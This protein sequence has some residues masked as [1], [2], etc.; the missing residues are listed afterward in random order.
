MTDWAIPHTSKIKYSQVFNSNDGQR[1]GLLTG[2][3]ARNI[4]IKSGLSQQILAQIWFLSDVDKDGMLTCEEFILSMHLI[5]CVKKGLPLPSVLP[6]ELLPSAIKRNASVVSPTLSINSLKDVKSGLPHQASIPQ[7]TTLPKAT[8]ISKSPVANLVEWNIP[9]QSKLKYGQLF[10]QVDKDRTG[11]LTGI[12]ARNI[13]IK[14]GLSNQHLAN[15]WNL[16]DI[17]K[18]GNL[19]SEEFILSMHLIDLV[20]AG[21]TL[22][23]TLPLE[24]IPLSFRRKQSINGTLVTSANNAS[25]Q[26][27][28]AALITQASTESMSN[29][30]TFEDKRKENFEKG[31][32]ELEKRRQLLLEQQK[33]EQEERERKEKEEFEKKERIRL[34]QERKKKEELERQLQK[35][36]ELE[37]QKEEERKKQQELKEAARREM[38]RQRLIEWENQKKSEM[39]TTKQ[40][41]QEA[42]INLKAKKQ[43]MVVDVGQVNSQLN[44]LKEKVEETRQK[45]SNAKQEIDNMRVNRDAKLKE[46]NSLKN[47]IKVLQERHLIIEQ[48]KLSLSAQLKNINIT[49]NNS[50]TDSAD[51]ALKS[52]QIRIDQLKD[53]LSENEKLKD[54][55]QKDM[56][57]HESELETFKTKYEE[58]IER[59]NEL[60]RVYDEKR[61]EALEV[62][63]KSIKQAEEASKYASNFNAGWGDDGTVS[64]NLSSDVNNDV[65]KYRAIYQ[66][67]GANLD[68]LSLKVGDIINS[69]PESVAE[70]GWLQG[71]LNGKIGWFPESYV[72]IYNPDAI[73]PE[74]S[75]SDSSKIEKT[76]VNTS[77]NA[78][79]Y[80]Q[81]LYNWEG[82]DESH[83]SIKKGDKVKVLDKNQDWIFG[84]CNNKTGWVPKTYIYL[85][86]DAQYYISSFAFESQE[87]G[88]L[89]FDVNE[90][91]YVSKKE[92]QWWTGEITETRKGVFP[93]TFVREATYEE[94]IA[95]NKCPS[96]SNLTNLE[97]E[98]KKP[99]KETSSNASVQNTPLKSTDTL[100]SKKSKSKKPE[101]VSVIANYKANGKEQLDL[102]KGQLIQVRKK[103]DSGWW[104]GEIQ[105]KGKKRQIGW[106]PAAYVKP[107]GG[108]T[109][110]QPDTPLKA[111]KEIKKEV[112]KVISSYPYTASQDDELSFDANEVIIVLSKDDATWW[113]GESE[114][115]GKQGLFPSN[116][117]QPFNKSIIMTDFKPELNNVNLPRGFRPV[118]FNLNNFSNNENYDQYKPSEL[119]EVIYDEPI[120][121]FEKNINIKN[122]N[123]PYI[124]TSSPP[125]FSSLSEKNR[126]N[127]FIDLNKKNLNQNFTDQPKIENVWQLP[128]E[129]QE[130]VEHHLRQ[131]LSRTPT[132]IPFDQ[133]TLETVEKVITDKQPPG[134]AEY[135]F[136]ND[137]YKFYTVPSAIEKTKTVKT[138]MNLNKQKVQGIGPT[139][140]TGM[141]LTLRTLRKHYENDVHKLGQDELR[142]R[143]SQQSPIPDSVVHLNRYEKNYREKEVGEIK[144]KIFA[145]VLRD[146]RAVRENEISVQKGDI[147]I[148]RKQIDFNWVEIEDC[149]SGL[150]GFVPR[151]F[152]DS[153]QEGLAKV[154]YTF[155]AKHPGEIS[156]TKYNLRFLENLIGGNHLQIVIV[157]YFL[158]PA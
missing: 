112:E 76:D 115:T 91:I 70:S 68:D 86:E 3:Q 135:L 9:Q 48:E 104:E 122:Q 72:E 62:I 35:Q 137:S 24:L 124:P 47:Q 101:I 145:K 4:L 14:S 29:K 27:T 45:V 2:V 60:Q 57:L 10:N 138:K 73:L 132:P 42:L 151:K 16:S 15:I 6:N 131:H 116:Y 139:T 156:L 114:T 50:I 90:L 144:K 127:S 39:L 146:F 133:N 12:Q 38:E 80:V 26:S 22:P 150:I 67:D 52:K 13:L 23:L 149:Q 125:H 107:L 111:K 157:L 129:E 153:E 92:D 118:R 5:D 108:N 65:I 71:E 33:R 79:S 53:Q 49:H 61:K 8:E 121:N 25:V 87:E 88:D 97:L 109:G 58:I 40:R 28:N 18:D 147:V 19:A 54:T 134:N 32:A 106:F 148:I 84:E 158:G 63:E 152:L 41:V 113:K 82:T 123:P 96:S 46:M 17:D 30:N 1:T 140:E 55:K 21:E 51:F 141:P 43:R 83:L 130:Q 31:Q 154:K 69:I 117:V 142:F 103:L 66:F 120:S 20:K 85:T 81:V 99:L 74:S 78:E 59:T 143:S 126:T 64:N 94:I 102:E 105:I 100:K 7:S 56:E 128:I 34:E 75:L 95:A 110:N 44:G 36:K 37:M 11:Y 93:S 98:T 77:S 119:N 89:T 136:E 155:I